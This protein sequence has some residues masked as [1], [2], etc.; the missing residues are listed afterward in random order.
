MKLS[1]P[2]SRAARENFFVGRFGLAQRDVV[3]QFSEEQIGILHRETDAGA[4][5]R[6]IVLPRIDAIDEDAAFLGFVEAEQQTPDR[7]L[8]RTDPADDADPFASLDLERDLFQRFAGG[9]RIG[10]ADVL[11]SDRVLRSIFLAT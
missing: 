10:E 11:E 6:R 5:I 7:G 9:V 8:A 1:T 4:Q 2:D 3:A